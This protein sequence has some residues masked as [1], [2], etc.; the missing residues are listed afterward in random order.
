MGRPKIMPNLKE[1]EKLASRGLTMQQI[2]DALG[3]NKSTLYER[4]AEYQDFSN[5]IKKGQAKGIATVANALFKNA[6]DGD[7]GAQCFFLKCRADWREKDTE[8][9]DRDTPPS[10]NVTINRIDGRKSD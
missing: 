1:V 9:D 4:K 6:T 5:A 3:I 2:A 7:T 8:R 10:V